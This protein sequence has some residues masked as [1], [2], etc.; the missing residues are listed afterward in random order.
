MYQYTWKLPVL[1]PGRIDYWLWWNYLRRYICFLF[2]SSVF[3]ST[4]Y[5]RTWALSIVIQVLIIAIISIALFQISTSVRVVTCAKTANATTRWDLTSVVAKKVIPSRERTPVARTTTN[6]CW[7]HSTVTSMPIVP[8]PKA[9][10]NVAVERDS[11]ATAQF[12]AILTNVWQTTADAIRTLS[13]STRKG[14]LRF[15]ST[16]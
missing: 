1:V 9:D 16:H 5:R 7:G 4:V 3:F 11:P 14:P 15:A 8:T 2:N 6:V 13:V 12:A 10:T